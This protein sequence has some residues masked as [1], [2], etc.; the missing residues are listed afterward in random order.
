MSAKSERLVT[1]N[2]CQSQNLKNLT[3]ASWPTL[4]L[5]S[6][7]LIILNSAF[8]NLVFKTKTMNARNHIKKSEKKNPS[9]PQTKR[10][11]KRDKSVKKFKANVGVYVGYM[12]FLAAIASR[13]QKQKS[14]TAFH[15][16]VEYGIEAVRI[17]P[18]VPLK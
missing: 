6:V 12:R 18:F 7:L 16:I 9:S 2:R 5:F 3:A 15:S 10:Q 4:C 11:I 8:L 17:F 13:L 1:S 14:R